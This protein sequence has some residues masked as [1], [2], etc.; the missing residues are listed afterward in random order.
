MRNPAHLGIAMLLFAT[1]ASG[2]TSTDSLEPV[3]EGCATDENWRTFDDYITT[4]RITDDPANNP[5]VLSPME[6][7]TAPSGAPVTFTWQPTA[8][9][10][11][12][13]S[14]NVSCAKYQPQSLGF[15]P[16]HEPPVS[17]I[18]YDLHLAVG[19]RDVYRVVTTR[20]RATLP[21]STWQGLAG[22]HVTVTL[23]SAQLLRNDVTQ[24]PFM[25][26]PFELFVM[27]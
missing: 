18:V 6:G 7:S 21:Q 22:K 19:G 20:Q 5:K 17:G 24:G 15:H 9:N 11:G 23:Y 2:C 14:G 10:A 4:Q 12:T 8:T 3:Y 16:L 27:P 25:A 13:A 26:K 1:A